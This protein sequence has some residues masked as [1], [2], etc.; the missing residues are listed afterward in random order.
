MSCRQQGRREV[1]KGVRGKRGGGRIE[2]GI[3]SWRA[4]ETD[5]RETE[6][7]L[8]L[9]KGSSRQIITDLEADEELRGS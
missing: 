3:D 7:R 2:N 9:D 4:D 6:D 1:E 5:I 8:K